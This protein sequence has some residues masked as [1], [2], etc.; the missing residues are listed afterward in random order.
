MLCF[1]AQT[2]RILVTPTFCFHSEVSHGK[3]IL[4]NVPTKGK[5][6]SMEPA[7]GDL[8][9]DSPWTL[10]SFSVNEWSP[11]FP[12]PRCRCCWV[13]SKFEDCLVWLWAI[14]AGSIS[15]LNASSLMQDWF[16]LTVQTFELI[17]RCLADWYAKTHNNNNISRFYSTLVI[18]TFF[19]FSKNQ[20]YIFSW[21]LLEIHKIHKGCLGDVGWLCA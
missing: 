14:P 3:R 5:Y 10:S 21:I 11:R 1:Q 7:H 2:V 12:N 6:L 20:L 15:P 9:F 13:L 4:I 19:V 16:S 8:W 18:F 17:H